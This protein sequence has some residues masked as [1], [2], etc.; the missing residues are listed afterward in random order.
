SGTRQASQTPVSGGPPID[1]RAPAG[2][3][4]TQPAGGTAVVPDTDHH[5]VWMSR[6]SLPRR[7]GFD[8]D[9]DDIEPGDR[10]LLI[11]ENDANFAK[12]LLEMAREK[13]FQ[14]LCSL[15]GHACTH[16]S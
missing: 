15:E 11:I 13:G 8:D 2:G 9:R 14:G 7:E 12:V 6:D 1:L 3:A 16:R 5:A 10:T 4:W